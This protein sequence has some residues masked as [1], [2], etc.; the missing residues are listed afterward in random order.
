MKAVSIKLMIPLIALFVAVQA[1]ARGSDR[2][3]FNFGASI[4]I[5]NKSD[6]GMGADSSTKS[7][8]LSEDRTINPYAGFVI[9]EHLNLGLALSFE[10][11]TS[12]S[13]E[14]VIGTTERVDRTRNSSMKSASFFGRFLFG[15]AM[16]FEAGVGL[17]DQS[18]SVENQYTFGNG[19]NS[20]SGKRENYSVRGVGPGYHAGGGFEIEMGRRSG[21]YLTTTYMVRSYALKQVE[22]ESSLGEELSNV[23]RQEVAFGL[24]H[25]VN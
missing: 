9:G 25:Y 18:V 5:Q 22:G 4:K 12:E 24:S 3:G 17:Y 13:S 15:D 16:F 6:K 8:I 21:F 2:E 19:D 14:Q 1:Q 11:A 23:T 10:N 20:F 7:N